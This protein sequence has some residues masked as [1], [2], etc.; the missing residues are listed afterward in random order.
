MTEY[1]PP[2]TIWIACRDSSEEKRTIPNHKV[3]PACHVFEAYGNR[4]GYLL[5][6]PHNPS[7]SLAIMPFGVGLLCH[8]QW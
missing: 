3:W 4:I 8:L 7:W 6:V 5:E 2:S 1:P